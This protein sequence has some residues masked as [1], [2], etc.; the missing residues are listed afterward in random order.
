MKNPADSPNNGLF[1]KTLNE[2][3]TVGVLPV[4]DAERTMTSG[5]LMI[6]WLMASASAMTPLIGLLLF[7][8]GMTDMILAILVSWL[9]SFI[10]AGLFSEMGREVPLTGLIVARKTYGRVGAFLFAVLFTF[11]NMG[12]FGLN[13]AVA[14]EVLNAI[15]HATG[16]FWFWVIGAA[17]VILVLFGMKWLEYFYR[18]TSVLL[19]L[20]YGAL[21]WYLFTHFHITT[22]HAT[23]AM[24]WGTAI[25]T[26]VSFSILAWT[27]KLSTVSRFCVPKSSNTGNARYFLA[28]SIGIMLAVLLMGIVGMDA[29]Q[30]TGNWNVA[31]L[32]PHIPVWG[33]AAA[34]G[35]ALAIIHTNAMNLYPSTVDLLV[36]L[37]TL[38][39]STRWEQ[40]VA[41][42][43]L[44]ILSTV[45]AVL[46]ILNHV[47]NFLDAI[48]DVIVPFTFIMLVDWLWVQRR[49]TP[50]EAFFTHPEKPE[51]WMN[52][53]SIVAFAAGL[54]FSLWGARLAPDLFATVLPLPVVGGLVSAVIYALWRVRP[55]RVNPVTQGKKAV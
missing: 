39:K 33:L 18:Y 2:I 38:R 27:Y 25:S 51:D 48:G 3:E 22:P 11:V 19:L 53:P 35:V 40:P 26:V 32:G 28:P 1:Q 34:L 45:L 6:V 16:S 21:T 43:I 9:I 31:L 54:A 20:C 12:W 5:K 41:T 50:A 37:N 4:P 24:Q 42:I 8:F 46:G 7:H 23:T 29:Q 30:A 52:W 17:Q 10:P 13:T 36:A 14:G 47:S 55:S 15:F 49:R 44:G